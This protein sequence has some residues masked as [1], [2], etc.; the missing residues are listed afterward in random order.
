MADQYGRHETCSHSEGS[1]FKIAE[2]ILEVWSTKI[3]KNVAFR[4]FFDGRGEQQQH[5][6][7]KIRNLLTF[8]YPY[9]VG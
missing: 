6:K 1:F 7:L 5:T 8:H 9:T 4:N 3:G 2:M